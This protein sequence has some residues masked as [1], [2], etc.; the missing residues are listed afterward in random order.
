M[1]VT[2]LSSDGQ[3]VVTLCDLFVTRLAAA[4]YKVITTIARSSKPYHRY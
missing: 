2:S 3:V 4:C 1:L